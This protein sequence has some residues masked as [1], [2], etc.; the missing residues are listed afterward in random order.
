MS[1]S[2]PSRSVQL[3]RSW[4]Y[5]L[6]GAAFVCVFW[7]VWR[8]V[9][10]QTDVSAR[11]L[12]ISDERRKL[13]EIDE[14]SDSP[15]ASLHAVEVFARRGRDAVPRL[16]EE[17]SAADP[18]ARE[19]ALVGLATIGPAAADA[20]SEIRALLTDDSPQVRANAVFALR[21]ITQNSDE[22]GRAAAQMLADP[23]AEVREVAVT[24]LLV[25][26]PRSTKI[27][28]EQLHNDLPVARSQ[29]LR[30]LR[31]W[32]Q[33]RP[34]GGPA[35]LA[36]IREPVR[37]LLDDADA[38]VRID[39]L[40]AVVAWGIAEPAEIS[41][42]LQHEDA[43]RVD[44]AL[45]AIPGRGE[46]AADLLPEVIDLVDRLQLETAP[47]ARN[48]TLSKHMHLILAALNSMKTAA[49]PA[50]PR[51]I[52]L[53]QARQDSTRT[54]ITETLAAIG[55]ETDDLV[56]VLTPLLLDEDQGVAWHA[57]QLLVEVSPEAARREVSKI[58]PQLGS[59]SNVNKSVLYALH[60]LGREAREAAP[61][62]APLVK[63][64]DP[65]VSQFAK[66]VLNDIGPDA[67]PKAPAG[68]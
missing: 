67:V 1:A 23:D 39:T 37:S 14:V 16:V 19:F 10:T 11:Q 15:V 65:W 40:T 25:I 51:L 22:A 20:V 56:P 5:L 48:H 42:L 4:Q 55:T 28:L 60:A 6:I 50:A 26:G 53:V 46:R 35:W 29:A 52:R 64:G 30:V 62:V 2:K 3:S 44:V 38:G 21:L 17:L 33:P 8:E 47:A 54:Q 13:S 12:V 57:G 31:G 36:E 66:Y 7:L 27:V 18:K 45:A 9:H 58:L 32:T 49:R 68:E 41:E 24:Q 34:G 63:N 43:A 61:K 59:G